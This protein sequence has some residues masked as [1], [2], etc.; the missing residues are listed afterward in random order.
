VIYLL[1]TNVLVWFMEADER[2]SGLV[3][4]LIES[5]IRRCRISRVS[6]WEVLIKQ[7]LGKLRTPGSILDIVQAMGLR[8]WGLEP[9]HLEALAA[10]REQALT[11]V[12]D[13][14]L[15]AQAMAEQATLVTSDS[16][17]L[18]ARLRGLAVMDSRA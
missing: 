5:E 3:V 18:G 11:D 12:F 6:L 14:L 1:D 9:H 15:V 4:E 17:I 13:E 10:L 7:R 2:L 8:E 16:R